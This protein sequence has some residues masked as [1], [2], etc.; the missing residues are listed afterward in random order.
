MATYQKVKGTQDFYGKQILLMRLV[1]NTAI[2][3]VRQFGFQE[4][5]TPTFE[6]T[7]V[8][9][10]SVGDETDIVSKE[11]YTFLDKGNRSITLRPE[12]TAAVAR[13]FIEN[14]LFSSA[15]P[16]T[17]WYY[18]GSMF[19]YERPQAGRYREFHQFGVEVFSPSSVLL[20]CDVILSAH[21]IFK[22]LEIKNIKLK[23]NS[24]GDFTSRQ[25]YAIALTSY[26][27][28]YRELMCPDCNRRLHTNPL[29]ILDCK[30]D[31]DS[32]TMKNAPKISDFLTEDSKTYFNQLCHM[33]DAFQVNYEV[34]LNLVRGL[35]YYTDTV[36]EFIIESDDELNGLT[37]C[38][39]GKYADLLKSLNGIDLP[40]IG[41][42][43]G[44]ERIM[45]IIEKQNHNIKELPQ[46]DVV[47]IGLD[48]QAKQESLKWA[49]QLRAHGFV[50]EFDYRSTS[51]KNQFKFAERLNARMILII[52]EEEVANQCVTVKDTMMKT[53]E[54]VENNNLITYLEQKFDNHN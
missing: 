10:R 7:E 44:I 35:D 2:N 36:F 15:L 18:F 23:I 38:A 39:G 21:Q 3:V 54:Q 12:G 8:F 40:G 27:N 29:R 37:V 9:S 17:K 14:K 34:D 30:V 4:I 22:T 50:C 47:I 13:S 31:R 51:L 52:G 42:A 41:Y 43:F 26:F 53:Q 6:H 5:K 28:Q 33:L 20:D 48:D 19:R 49:Y 45:A 25:N 11:M 32:I 24:I 16:F 1:E 46:I